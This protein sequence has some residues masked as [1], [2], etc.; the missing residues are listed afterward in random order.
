MKKD[1][2]DYDLIVIGSGPA[3]M[4]AASFALKNKLKTLLLEKS[5]CEGGECAHN[6]CIPAKTM[7]HAA[8]V[9]SD[10][11]NGGY[12]GIK[13]STLGYNFP[14]IAKWRDLAVENTGLC[15]MLKDMQKKGLDVIQAEVKFAG[16]DSIKV[17]SRKK[18]KFKH[19]IIA[20]GGK[21]RVP[22]NI[23]GL[24]STGF[25]TYNQATQITKVPKSVAIIGGSAIGC[26]FMQ[27]FSALGSK[28][29]VIDTADYLMSFADVQASELM[30]QIYT[31]RGT[32]IYLGSKLNSVS[33]IG[34]KK[35]L[36]LTNSAG[37]KLKIKVDEI[38]IASGKAPNTDLNLDAAKVEFNPSGI[39]VNQ[40][41][42]TTNKNI[43]AVGDVVGP[44]KFT[45]TGIY[46][47][48]IAVYN[49][50]NQRKKREADYS[51]IACNIFTDPELSSLGLTEQTAI[52]KDVDYVTGFCDIVEV[53]RADTNGEQN[54]FVKIIV[55]RQSGLILGS[56]IIAPRAGEMIQEL[57]LAMKYGISIQ[58]VAEMVHVF[59]TWSEAIRIAANRAASKLN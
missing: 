11:R 46:Q 4:A 19:A 24:D 56:T 55:D 27:L 7:M 44:L 26:E 9:Y 18:L 59:P 41:L 30:R 23:E 49:I 58:E 28:V 53:A 35:E 34:T 25:L 37:Q 15:S 17:G 50:L 16:P 48:E 20:T 10:A 57:S 36:N 40:K 8:K 39:E 54:G 47:A 13:S 31:E 42:E 22:S 33:K 52:S 45:H 43:Y 38:V 6:G 21:A 12:M 2:Y 14:S 51:S 3:G 29:S 1:K 32:D 5:S